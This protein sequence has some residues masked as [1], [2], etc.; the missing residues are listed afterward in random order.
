M[1]GM[2]KFRLRS[3]QPKVRWLAVDI[4]LEKGI[5]SVCYYS[6]IELMNEPPI[7]PNDNSNPYAAPSSEVTYVDDSGTFPPASVGKR[8]LNYLL[9]FGAMFVLSMGVGLLWA[10]AFPEQLAESEAE[11][12]TSSTSLVST[13]K[14]NDTMVGWAVL[15]IY[16]L[17]FE[18][19]TGRSLGKLITGTKVVTADQQHRASFLQILGRSIAR[20]IPFEQFSILTSDHRMWHDSLSKTIV[21]DVRARK[22]PP[23]PKYVPGQKPLIIRHPPSMPK[24][25]VPAPTPQSPGQSPGPDSDVT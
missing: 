23:R 21:V 3:S 1:G 17:I 19:T 9:D 25:P 18:A 13:G 16:Y 8:F 6:I 12:S 20:L 4:I 7:P 10:L 5:V 14:V 15:V 24:I 22:I 2:E 11:S